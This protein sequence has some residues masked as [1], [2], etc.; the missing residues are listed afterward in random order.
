LVEQRIEN[1][2]VGGSIPPQATI[3]INGLAARASSPLSFLAAA[4]AVP[5]YSR[6]KNKASGPSNRQLEP[7]LQLVHR[8]LNVRAVLVRKS[9]RCS[10]MHWET[11]E[12][13]QREHDA[14]VNAALA[15]MALKLGLLHG[16]L[17]AIDA[18]ISRWRER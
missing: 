11:F 10:V 6:Q 8:G 15:G 12:R 17:G 7:G 3:Q 16:R 14:Q 1:P 9:H 18:E 4:C 13:L 2:R 5:V